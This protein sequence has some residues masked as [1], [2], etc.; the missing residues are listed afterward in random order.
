M[1]TILG[2]RLLKKPSGYPSSNSI[3]SS[4]PGKTK[5][6]YYLLD[7]RR[8]SV[9]RGV[10]VCPFEA[11]HQNN[12]SQEIFQT[13]V[14]TI[15]IYQHSMICNWSLN[16]RKFVVKKNYTYLHNSNK[17]ATKTNENWSFYKWCP[18]LLYFY[19]EIKQVRWVALNVM[20]SFSKRL[21]R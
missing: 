9:Y 16:K 8:V 7:S 6:S 4:L 15:V 11:S 18:Y 17:Y 14:C 20:E 21:L 13:T 3:W 5:C 10:D 19:F 12:T 2:L 1:I